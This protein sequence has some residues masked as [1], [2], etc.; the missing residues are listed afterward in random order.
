M[1]FLLSGVRPWSIVSR[2]LLIGMG[3]LWGL[4]TQS[5]AQSVELYAGHERAGVDIL[6][7]RFLQNKEAQSTPFL[8]FSRTR[9]STTYEN[10]P[11]A[12]G[13]TNAISYNFKNGLGVVG[14]GSFLNGGFTPKAGIQLVKAKG[15]LLFFGWLVADLK[16]EGSLDLFGLVR[17]QPTLYRDWRLFSQAELFPVYTPS[18]AFWS[19]TQR[20]RLGTKNHHWGAGVMADFNQMGRETFTRTNNIGGFLRHDF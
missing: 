11:T 10:A 8:F 18:R 2:W 13:T 16:K 3:G 19:L 17:W 14:V 12:F 1:L 7:Y 5:H 9:A 4:L 6:W 15:D 20:F